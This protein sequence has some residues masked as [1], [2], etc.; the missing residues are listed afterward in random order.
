M[1]VIAQARRRLDAAILAQRALRWVAPAALAS[2]FVL[3]LAELAGLRF[4]ALPLMAAVVVAAAGAGTASAWKA[5]MDACQAA[6]W[7]D[8]G[9]GDE[10]LLSAALCCI[11]EP[12]RREFG[13]KLVEAAA[14]Q[15]PRARTLRASSLPLAKAGALAIAALGLGLGAMALAGS[16][17]GD[18]VS[19]PR[20]AK[21]GA[22][23][24]Q[25]LDAET[26]SAL[27]SESVGGASSFASSLFPEDKRLAKLTERALREGRID[28][29]RDLLN[30]ADLELESRMDR[31]IGDLERSKLGEER[32][33]I[34]EAASVLDRRGGS[35]KSAGGSRGRAGGDGAAQEEGETENRYSRA[36]PE[37]GGT[38]EYGQGGAPGDSPS[39]GKSGGAFG[40]G[41][42]GQDSEGEQNYPG[43]RG[44][45]GSGAGRGG[46][47]YGTGQGAE[48]SWGPIEGQL[49]TEKAVIPSPKDSPFF[50]LVLPGADSSLPLS[51]IAPASAK[52]AESAMSRQSVPL[53]YEEF[54][55]SYFLSLSKGDEQ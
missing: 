37:A 50:E 33:R 25:A 44:G 43:E 24:D 15:L 39:S 26:A 31:P 51:K 18:A 20:V 22:Q 7:L 12:S 29:L 46:S 11:E 3:A 35:G 47:S 4:A 53:E 2:G 49:S 16:A 19:A 54:V 34:Q 41:S 55:R 38:P 40:E 23:G 1:R 52:S 21:A 17:R 27:A 14:A 6:R 10:E 28:D 45:A 9:L 5:R 32:R 8:R 13:E 36:A 48:G 42:G 30:A